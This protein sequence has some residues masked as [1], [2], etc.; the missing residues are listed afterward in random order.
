VFLI[1][2]A[3]LQPRQRELSCASRRA[4]AARVS[5]GTRQKCACRRRRM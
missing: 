2:L 1:A 4:S 3:L 5:F